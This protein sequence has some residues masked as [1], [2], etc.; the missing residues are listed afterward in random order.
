MKI[1][2]MTKRLIK[3]INFICS[4]RILGG[5]FFFFSFRGDSFPPRRSGDRVGGFYVPHLIRVHLLFGAD[6]EDKWATK[7]ASNAS[8]RVLIMRGIAEVE[9][10]RMCRSGGA[11]RRGSLDLKHALTPNTA[12]LCVCVC[13]C[14]WGGRLI[15]VTVTHFVGRYDITINDI[16][17]NAIILHNYASSSFWSAKSF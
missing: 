16:I 8:L 6:G 9:L 13:V 3:N 11:T 10:I 7:A 14:A 2:K 12:P 5:S 15:S 4:G 17:I 1:I